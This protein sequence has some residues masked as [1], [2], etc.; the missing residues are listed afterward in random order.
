MTSLSLQVYRQ[1]KHIVARDLACSK[2][3][4]SKVWHVSANGAEWQ[5]SEYGNIPDLLD[6]FLL[7]YQHGG[8]VDV[9]VLFARRSYPGFNGPISGT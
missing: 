4:L 3:V 5:G 9:S 2:R 1:T 8:S 6:L 7:A